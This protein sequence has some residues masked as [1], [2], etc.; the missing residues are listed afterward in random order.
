MCT[1][2]LTPVIYNLLLIV[3][4]SM[5]CNPVCDAKTLDEIEEAMQVGD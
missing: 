5:H 2:P 3:A 4:C 1:Q